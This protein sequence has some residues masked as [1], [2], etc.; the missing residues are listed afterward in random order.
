MGAKEPSMLPPRPRNDWRREG[1]RIA[2][3]LLPPP[4]P[5]ARQRVSAF[6]RSIDALFSKT[7]S[8]NELA[9]KATEA[10][11]AI[12]EKKRKAG[13]DLIRTGHEAE[14]VDSDKEDEIDLSANG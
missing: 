4:A 3:F 5:A 11:K 2:T 13:R 12:I 6:E 14:D 9:D 10:L 8:P 1:R 7:I